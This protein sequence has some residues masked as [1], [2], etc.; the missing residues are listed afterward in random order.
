MDWLHGFVDMIG[1][2]SKWSSKW[3][4]TD[5]LDVVAKALAESGPIDVTS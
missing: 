5:S 3:A 1:V 4:L 2:I